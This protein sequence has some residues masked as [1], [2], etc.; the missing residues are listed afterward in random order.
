MVD[1][2]V[3][4]LSSGLASAWCAE[5]ALRKFGRER[6]V[7]YFNDTRWE[8]PDLYR[9]LADL[10]NL[11]GQ[12]ITE[13]S[14]GRSPEELFYYKHALASNQMPFCSHILK[15]KRLQMF[16]R[17]GDLLV[18]GVGSDELER[19]R[20]IVG[21][22]QVVSSKLKKDIKLSFPLITENAPESLRDWLQATGVALPTLYRMG[23]THN[24]CYGGCVRAGKLQWKMLYE[25]LPEVY[26]DR[27][28]VER[29][30]RSHF[31]KNHSFFRD[32]TLEQF[33]RRIEKGQLSK[34]YLKNDFYLP[35]FECFGICDYAA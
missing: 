21:I 2:V 7:L 23:F 19:A 3:V 17:S 24:N 12:T 15:A 26:L 16:C 27:E 22:Y 32:E 29:E 5:W 25:K 35:L 31:G 9:F 33:R 28:R 14:D 8:H 6:V 1:R 18:F 10:A 13:D 30:W 34:H 11:Y 20:R 4:A